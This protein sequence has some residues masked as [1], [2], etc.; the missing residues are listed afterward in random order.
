MMAEYITLRALQVPPLHEKA[1]LMLFN[2]LVSFAM[3][4]Q[5]HRLHA[6]KIPAPKKIKTTV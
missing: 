2:S 4:E 3:A 5:S 1:K 6:H